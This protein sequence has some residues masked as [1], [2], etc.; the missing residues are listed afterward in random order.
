VF[1]LDFSRTLLDTHACAKRCYIKRPAGAIMHDTA[2]DKDFQL[3]DIEST[4]I[5]S[6]LRA[7]LVSS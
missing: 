4:L 2:K 1:Q 6:S 7:L 3:R 5:D